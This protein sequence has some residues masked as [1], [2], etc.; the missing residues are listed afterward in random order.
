[1][2]FNSITLSQYRISRTVPLNIFIYQRKL[3]L[4][5]LEIAIVHEVQFHADLCQNKVFFIV[6]PLY[7]LKSSWFK[8]V[9]VNIDLALKSVVRKYQHPM[10]SK[11]GSL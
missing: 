7:I 5:V 6:Q 11:R 1:M 4:C 9:H 2:I 3:L 10:Y 8:Y